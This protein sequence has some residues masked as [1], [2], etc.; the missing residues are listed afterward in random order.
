MTSI[1]TK[2][3]RTLKR[4]SHTLLV[5]NQIRSGTSVFKKVKMSSKTGK[6]IQKPEV[7]HFL[8]RWIGA[9]IRKLLGQRNIT[10]N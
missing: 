5:I 9:L 4:L 2:N 7:Y 8:E 10:G 1:L 6:M 3:L